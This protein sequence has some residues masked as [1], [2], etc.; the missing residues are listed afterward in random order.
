MPGKVA[1]LR[2]KLHAWRKSVGAQ[3]MAIN[4]NYD[5]NKAGVREEIQAD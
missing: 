5:P 2:A 4:P 1:D 3:E